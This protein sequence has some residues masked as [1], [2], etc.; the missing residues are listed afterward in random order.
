MSKLL[1]AFEG[2]DGAGKATQT[3]MLVEHLKS[4]GLKIVRVSFPRYEDTVGGQLLFEAMKSERAE[5]YNFSKADP[6]EASLLYVMDRIASREYLAKLIEDHDV[7]VF[8]RY[9]E[10]NLL[11]QGGKLKTEYER[12]KFADWLYLLEYAQFH[13][14][15]PDVVV[16]LTIPFWLSR[17]RA[18]RREDGGGPS[19]DA[20]EKDIEYVK[21]GHEGGLFY[22]KELG[23]QIINCLEEEVELTPEQV[24]NKITQ[25][26]QG[27]INALMIM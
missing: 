23:W 19:M 22:A 21:A 2:S 20:V 13:L 11:H 27:R 9:V 17:A 6:Y 7:V 14:P 16:Y 18:K 10:S 12:R 25:T 15:V 26:L 3:N 8:D 24:H 1:I 5:G 4:L